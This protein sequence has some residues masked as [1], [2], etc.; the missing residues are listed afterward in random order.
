L[1]WFEERAPEDFPER[2]MAAVTTHDLPTI[3]GLWTG[4][5]LE[6]QRRLGV[7]PNEESTARL[8][9]R[10]ARELGASDTT[11]LDDVVA[12]TYRLLARAPSAIL[13]ATL[14]YPLPA[15][16]RPNVPGPTAARR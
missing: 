16:A 7:N 8:R 11:A 13:C 1:R 12:G 6:E 10:L 5:D 3:A 14:E 4:S 15:Q 9:D 2:A